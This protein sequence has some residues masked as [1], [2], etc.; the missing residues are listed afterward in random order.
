[1]GVEFLAFISTMMRVKPSQMNTELKDEDRFLMTL[2][3]T[4]IQ[5]GLKTPSLDFTIN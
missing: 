2:F 3:K 4:W 1:M 5:L